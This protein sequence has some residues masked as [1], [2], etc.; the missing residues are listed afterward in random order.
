MRSCGYVPG[1]TPPHTEARRSPIWDDMTCSS[2][3]E[4]IYLGILLRTLR[5]PLRGYN[6]LFYF[7]PCQRRLIVR[8]PTVYPPEV[9]NS[10]H[11]RTITSS[12]YAFI[13]YQNIPC[14][15]PAS[16]LSSL[17]AAHGKALQV[18]KRS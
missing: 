16:A 10:H 17:S 9:I 13:Q 3:G 12:G 15:L 14:R 7:N 18:S 6:V 1:S 5:P 8:P 2:G 4:G 11:R